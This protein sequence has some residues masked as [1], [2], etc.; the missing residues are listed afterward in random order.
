MKVIETKTRNNFLCVKENNEAIQ[1][2]CN[3]V[4]LELYVLMSHTKNVVIVGILVE[5]FANS[6][7]YLFY[8]C[9]KEYLFHD[10][11]IVA[12]SHMLLM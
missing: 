10:Y 7:S 4:I 8:N 9:A 12:F 11:A 5:G 1:D 6:H 3:Y 2:K